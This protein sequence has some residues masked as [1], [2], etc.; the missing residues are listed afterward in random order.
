MKDIT[1]H[2]IS[3]DVQHLVYCCKTPCLLLQNRL[4]KIQSAAPTRHFEDTTCTQGIWKSHH[5]A[6]HAC[7]AHLAHRV[8]G[9]ALLASTGCGAAIDLRQMPIARS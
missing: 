6:L 4:S 3:P 9:I 7:V 8:A 1:G 5:A 2:S